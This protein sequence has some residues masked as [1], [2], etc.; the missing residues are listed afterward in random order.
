MLISASQDFSGPICQG[1]HAFELQHQK[2]QKALHSAILSGQTR[3]SSH[4]KCTAHQ[5]TNHEVE[6]GRMVPLPL[7][8]FT[9]SVLELLAVRPW[10]ASA[11][12]ESPKVRNLEGLSR[13]PV[14]PLCQMSKRDALLP[15]SSLR[16]QEETGLAMRLCV[17]VLPLVS[18]DRQETPT[19]PTTP[20]AKIFGNHPRPT[21]SGPVW[22]RWLTFFLGETR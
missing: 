19:A 12:L 21:R 20:T 3:H 17:E 16:V 18:D 11:S 15:F 14:A 1:R 7:P 6:V 13:I 9:T 2:A 4:G 10:H 22:R 8:F 5:E